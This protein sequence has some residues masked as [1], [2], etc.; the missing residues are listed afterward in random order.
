MFKRNILNILN[1]WKKS[2]NRKPLI[3]RGARQ[4]GKTVAINLFSKQYNNYVYLNLEK[5]ADKQLFEKSENLSQIIQ[6]IEL[7]KQKSLGKED[8]LLFIDEIQNSPK[9]VQMLRFFY[10]DYPHL[11]VVA[12]SSLLEA[13]MKHEGFSFPVGR[14]QFLY[15]H[16]VSFDE[17]L[18]AL[19][20]NNLYQ[21]LNEI[22][23]NHPPTPALH[24]LALKLFHQYMLVGGMPEVV[25]NYI[26]KQSIYSLTSIKESL[27]TSFEED[28]TKYSKFSDAKYLKHV[29]QHAPEYVGERIKYENFGQSGYK[30]REMKKA[31]DL[32]EYAMIVQ[33]VFGSSSTIPPVKINYRVSSKI[34][35]LD[36]GLMAYKLQLNDDALFV[37]NL[38]DLGRGALAEQI[39]GQTLVASDMEKQST[40]SFWYRNV[41]GSTAETDYIIQ[42][43]DRIIPIEVK[44]GKQGKLKS[45]HQFMLATNHDLAVRIY[46]GNFT[47]EKIATPEKT[48]RLL[49]IPFYLAFRLKDILNQ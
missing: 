1:N 35:Y 13:V 7:S 34:L 40:P 21:A 27:V 28:T 12:A 46:S 16:P 15:L 11:H 45:L 14:V 29:I 49:S 41:P 37:N 23:L 4:T 6:G 47:E 20:K 42:I 32:L 36:V 38:N 22:S 26:E 10:E 44:S 48:Y 30:S 33:R 24:D 39:V 8:T 31:F 19:N 3:V 5:E 17:F 18:L 43:K 9:A 25:A 2:K